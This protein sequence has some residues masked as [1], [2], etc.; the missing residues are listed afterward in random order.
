MLVVGFFLFM[1][2]NAQ[3]AGSSGGSKMMN[4]GKSNAQMLVG[5][6]TITFENPVNAAIVDEALVPTK[7][8][9]SCEIDVTVKYGE[10]KEDYLFVS[11]N[12]ESPDYICSRMSS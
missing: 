2:L 4:F 10:A 7:F 8:I 5:D 6:K 1:I 9:K 3:H 12:T 11:L